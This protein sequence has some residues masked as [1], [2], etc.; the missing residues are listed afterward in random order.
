MHD[1]GD[2]VW[3][4][5]SSVKRIRSRGAAAVGA[6]KKTR[7]KTRVTRVLCGVEPDMHTHAHSSASV[8]DSSLILSFYWHENV[9]MDGLQQFRVV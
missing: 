6:E 7:E 1:V 9:S 8:T 3:N 4:D 5:V 2:R